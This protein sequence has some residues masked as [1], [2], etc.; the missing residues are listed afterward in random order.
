MHHAIASVSNPIGKLHPPRG[1]W[2]SP[3]TEM[4]ARLHIVT[5]PNFVE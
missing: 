2:G 1:E 3:L 5:R 4:D